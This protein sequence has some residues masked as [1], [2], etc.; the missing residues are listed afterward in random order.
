MNLRPYLGSIC[1]ILVDI[2]SCHQTIHPQ[3]TYTMYGYVHGIQDF[4]IV[5]EVLFKNMENFQVHMFKL[6]TSLNEV[7][8]SFGSSEI[9]CYATLCQIKE[10]PVECLI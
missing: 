1:K 2:L 8:K 4:W 3:P 6:L 7:P 10:T 5:Y 9:K